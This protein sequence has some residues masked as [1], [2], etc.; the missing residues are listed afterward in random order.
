MRL[1][2]I[3]AAALC[4]MGEPALAQTAPQAAPTPAVAAA[5]A[6]LEAATRVIEPVFDALKAEGAAVRADA[7]LTDQQKLIR[8]GELIAARQPEIDRFILVLQAYVREQAL[9]DGA[10]QEEA[11]AAAELYRGL[12]NQSVLQTMATGGAPD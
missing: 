4:L 6:D 11:V 10:T 12:I 8:I 3:A 2:S 9:A 7:T 5:R 1:L